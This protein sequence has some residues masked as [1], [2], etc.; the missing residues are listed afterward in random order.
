MAQTLQL[1]ISIPARQSYVRVA[2]LV[3]NGKVGQVTC[4]VI[5]RPEHNLAKKTI[6]TEPLLF[7][8]HE[9]DDGD[10]WGA[11]INSAPIEVVGNA[12]IA[13]IILVRKRF[14]AVRARGASGVG[15]EARLHFTYEGRFGTGQ[16]DVIEVGSGKAGYGFKGHTGQGQPNYSVTA[17]P[18]GSPT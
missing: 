5:N 4:R 18:D 12:E 14:L 13:T 9:S 2:T 17:W 8:F 3:S 1:P 6:T 16:L 11:P 15:G 7:N 10:D